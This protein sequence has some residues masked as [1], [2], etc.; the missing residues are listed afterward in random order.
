M[1]ESWINDVDYI[2]KDTSTAFF[3]GWGKLQKE[4]LSDF[5]WNVS[6]NVIL[7]GHLGVTYHM[8]GHWVP[9][10]RVRNSLLWYKCLINIG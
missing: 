1:I 8:L 7:I 2:G 3:P 4:N 5:I 9:P 10:C 6:A